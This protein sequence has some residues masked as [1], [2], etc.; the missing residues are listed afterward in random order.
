LRVGEPVV[1]IAQVLSGGRAARERLGE[2]QFE[3]QLRALFG[4][5]RLRQC[6]RGICRGRREALVG[7]SVQTRPDKIGHGGLAE[8]LGADQRDERIA[9]DLSEERRVPVELGGPEAADQEHGQPLE[10]APQVGEKAQRGWIAPM[11]VVHRQ[12][13]WPLFAQVH[14]HPVE[15]V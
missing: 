11:Q 5:R 6:A 15:T 14:R 2:P 8:R 13:Q 4:R 1:R 12:Q 9:R 10:S 3:Q 7:G